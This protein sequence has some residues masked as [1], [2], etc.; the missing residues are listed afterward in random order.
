MLFITIFSLILLIAGIKMI[1]RTRGWLDIFFDN[2][3]VISIGFLLLLNNYS[4]GSDT[5]F[6][7]DNGKMISLKNENISYTFLFSKPIIDISYLDDT[8]RSYRVNLLFSSAKII[9][10]NSFPLDLKV[11]GFL[12]SSEIES[13]E[14]Y[15]S[16][17]DMDTVSFKDKK[18][19]INFK[20]YLSK[21]KIQ[22]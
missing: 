4:K 13:G 22:R 3:I 17:K 1:F 8:T 7:F 5:F 14:G 20:L 19:K 18:I 21:L 16:M 10:N 6:A 9:Q 2:L 12:Y 11:N 15:L